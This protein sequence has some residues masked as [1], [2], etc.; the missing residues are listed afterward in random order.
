MIFIWF[1]VRRKEL[2]KY[3]SNIILKLR[4]GGNVLVWWG[5]RGSGVKFLESKNVYI[6]YRN[7]WYILVINNEFYSKDIFKGI[8]LFVNILVFCF[9]FRR[10]TWYLRFDLKVR[11]GGDGVG[12]RWKKIGYVLIIV[13]VG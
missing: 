11:K 7:I 2:L 3:L 12:N 1:C 8:F 4:R 5:V 13:E 10:M 9:V 6:E